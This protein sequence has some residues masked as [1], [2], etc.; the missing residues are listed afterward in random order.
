MLIE[1]LGMHLREQ[2]GPCVTKTCVVAADT[3]GFR[4]PNPGRKVFSGDMQQQWSDLASPKYTSN[5]WRE[6]RL[7]RRR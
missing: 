4:E 1:M 6:K 3:A 2:R 5:T 7:T